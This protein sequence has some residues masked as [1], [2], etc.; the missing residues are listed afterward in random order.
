MPN[1]VQHRLGA[2]RAAITDEPPSASRAGIGRDGRLGFDNCSA[3]QRRFRALLALHVFNTSDM[4]EPFGPGSAA[5]FL[6]Y[7]VAMS[8]RHDQLVVIRDNAIENITGRLIPDRDGEFGVAGLRVAAIVPYRTHHLLHVPTGARMVITHRPV[9]PSAEAVAARR[10]AP[11]GWGPGP[12]VPLSASEQRAIAIAESFS[13]PMQRLLAGLM[14]RVNANDPGGRWSL[15]HWSTW[16]SQLDG[17]GDQCELRWERRPEPHHIAAAL[18]DPV[19]GIAGAT[20]TLGRYGEYTDIV[21]DG[22]RL[23]LRHRR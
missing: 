11:T 18:T 12:D 10:G 2:Q 14:V 15:W 20:S 13:V 4:P 19:A 3:A 21:L 5:A 6:T 9:F 7:T 16:V 23:R 8:P 1:S 22:A 17:A